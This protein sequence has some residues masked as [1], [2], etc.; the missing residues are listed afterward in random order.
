MNHTQ[1]IGLAVNRL[2]KGADMTLKDLSDATGLSQ[3]FLSKFERGQTTIA[4]D[5]LLQIATALG[6][7]IDRLLTQNDHSAATELPQIVHRSYENSVLYMENNF[8]HYQITNSFTGMDVLPKQIVLLPNMDP[9]Q[10]ARSSHR[11][12][13]F[14]YVLEGV[15][16]LEIGAVTYELYPGDTAHFQ[17]NVEHTWYN[18]TN[19]NTVIL[20]L[21]TPNVLSEGGNLEQLRAEMNGE[22]II[23]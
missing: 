18:R 17:S 8:I 12:Q 9:D 13:E 4:V 7:S 10:Y 14:V 19:K 2:R 5:S 21:H 16:T 15:L 22:S 20:T 11:G 6:T 1:Y 23:H 3:G